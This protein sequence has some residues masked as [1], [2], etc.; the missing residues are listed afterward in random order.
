MFSFSAVNGGSPGFVL[1]HSLDLRWDRFLHVS[2]LHTPEPT[3]S[4]L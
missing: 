4:Q 1:Y 3:P 2:F